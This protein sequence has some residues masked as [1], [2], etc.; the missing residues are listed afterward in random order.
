MPTRELL[1][2]AYGPDG[3][4]ALLWPAFCP[5]GSNR[6]LVWIVLWLLRWLLLYCPVSDRGL[7]LDPAH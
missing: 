7:D 3:Y 2:A 6:G 5:V 4:L 1:P